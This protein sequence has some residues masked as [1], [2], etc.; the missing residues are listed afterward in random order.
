VI[1]AGKKIH[2]FDAD[3]GIGP[4]LKSPRSEINNLVCFI[5]NN[6]DA[7]FVPK[8]VHNINIY[9]LPT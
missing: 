5:D 7:E 3:S 9:G 1:V 6:E 8:N 4:S 2:D